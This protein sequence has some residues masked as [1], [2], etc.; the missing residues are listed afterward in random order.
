M[1]AF[2]QECSCM[3]RKW[4]SSPRVGP[5]LCKF[6]LPGAP[7]AYLK[8]PNHVEGRGVT[9]S[10]KTVT[11]VQGFGAVTPNWSLT[12]HTR[13][14]AESSG[15]P[16]SMVP[17]LNNGYQT[18]TRVHDGRAN[19]TYASD[20]PSKAFFDHPSRFEWFESPAAGKGEGTFPRFGR[21]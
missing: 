13:E 14:Q 10:C 9:S 18:I 4:S 1:E 3:L 2:T 20:T 21:P 7:V 17:R 19:H 12:G 11:G 5:Q 15:K 16:P 8:Q 6:E